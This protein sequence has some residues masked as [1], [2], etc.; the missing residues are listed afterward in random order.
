MDVPGCRQQHAVAESYLPL[1]IALSR[2]HS[3]MSTILGCSDNK[4]IPRETTTRTCYAHEDHEKGTPRQASIKLWCS[5]CMSPCGF[6]TSHKPWAV[7]GKCICFTCQMLICASCAGGPVPA[8]AEEV[9]RCGIR[10]DRGIATVVS[11]LLFGG[12]RRS[13]VLYAFGGMHGGV[14]FLVY[15]G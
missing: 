4:C 5:C 15:T 11:N 3:R 12:K 9:Q 2:M 6:S 7:Y 10:V 1:V 13:R 14:W 8:T